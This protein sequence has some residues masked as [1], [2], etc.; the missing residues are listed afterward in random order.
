MHHF[1]R[2]LLVTFA[3]VLAVSVPTSAAPPDAKK[4][5]VLI[6]GKPSHPPRMHEFRAG[7]LLLQKCLASVPWLGG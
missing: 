7:S 1:A 3:T 2:L 5:L 4:K 6:A